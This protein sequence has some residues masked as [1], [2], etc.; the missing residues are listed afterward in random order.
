[1]KRITPI[2][3]NKTLSYALPITS[4][5]VF[6]QRIYVYV[7][8]MLFEIDGYETP[9]IIS[10]EAETVIYAEAAGNV[11]KG[12]ERKGPLSDCIGRTFRYHGSP[13]DGS[14]DLLI[15]AMGRN[16]NGDYHFIT[17]P[18]IAFQKLIE[19]AQATSSTDFAASKKINDGLKWLMEIQTWDIR[20]NFD[21]KIVFTD[22]EEKKPR[23]KYNSRGGEKTPSSADPEKDFE[24]ATKKLDWKRIEA[25]KEKN[26]EFYAK[27]L[28][29]MGFVK[30]RVLQKA[31]VNAELINTTEIVPPPAAQTDEPANEQPL[32]PKK[33]GRKPKQKENL[34]SLPKEI[35]I[36]QV[37]DNDDD[38][39]ALLNFEEE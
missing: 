11:V 2:Y 34:P 33:R 15:F 38:L 17:V 10:D 9:I 29:L 8:Y 6:G 31:G 4:P 12:E 26:P 25:M 35:G 24:E 7:L 36:D 20:G 30:K 18:V 5:N 23:F 39:R 27:F 19:D 16:A 3:I 28:R 32:V 37:P 14:K 1:M 22:E 13:E 21:D